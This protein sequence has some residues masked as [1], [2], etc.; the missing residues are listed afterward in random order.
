MGTSITTRCHLTRRQFARIVI[1][2]AA[3]TSLGT[4]V[5]CAPQPAA[6]RKNN[7]H[8]SRTV[9][10]D[11]LVVG[12]GGA[13]V[14]AAAAAAGAQADTILI[15]KLPWLAG[16]SSLAIGTFYGADTNLQ[17]A[18]GID[19]NADDLLA[20][21]LRRG[22]DKLDYDIQKFCAD[23]F[24]ETINWLADDLQVPF[25]DTVSLKG[26]DTVPRGHNCKTSALDAL[27]AVTQLARENGVKFHFSTAARELVIENGTVTG[28]IASDATGKLVRY[29]AKKT[30]MASGGFCR[31]DEMI[32]EYM[33]DYAGVYTEVGVG[34]TG[35]GLRMGLDAGADYI[36]HG[37]TNGILSCPIEPGQSKL[38]SKTVMWVDSDGN[39]FV[40]EGGQTHDI[41]YTVA[42]FPDKKFFAIYDQAAYEAL[43]DKQKNNLNRG[44]TDG[45]AAKADTLEA[46]CNA[47]GVN[48]QTAAITL[49]SYNEMAEA[50]VDTQFNKKAD[51][52]KALT[53]APYYVIQM[54]VCTH[55]S[56]GGY[57]VNT[58]FQV[59]DTTGAPIENYYA[60]GEVCCGTFI[61]DDYPSGGCGLNWS[62]TSGRFA[63]ANAAQAALA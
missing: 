28:V 19:D 39:R 10:C 21:F 26:T 9:S 41:Y 57:R 60:A 53:Q 61:Y 35:E 1:G 17:K 59:L 46:V 55:G 42:R 47:M 50:G 54:G 40:N 11:V 24:G 5:G 44:V 25:K 14:S 36:G 13:G 22:G 27:D 23:H 3:A 29:Q 49:A 2:G 7:E 43:G 16:S 51:N 62:Y 56:F 48:A 63:G 15:E 38:I 37:G 6:N 12:G 45:L 31:N 30:I 32:A 33:P 4:L 52:L 20:Y 58:D 34:L 18:Q 8:I